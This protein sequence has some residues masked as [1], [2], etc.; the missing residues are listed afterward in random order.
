MSGQAFAADVQKT[1]VYPHPFHRAGAQE[2]RRYCTNRQQRPQLLATRAS[3]A[4]GLRATLSKATIL[5]ASSLTIC[6]C[7]SQEILAGAHET[8]ETHYSSVENLEAVDS[9]ALRNAHSTIDMCAYSLT[10]HALIEAIS[11]AAQKGV[12]VRIYLDRG[13][14]AG[15]LNRENNHYSAD[16]AVAESEGILRHLAGTPNVTVRVKHSNTLMH[17][18]SYLIDSELLRTGSAN[19][20]PTGEKRQDNDLAFSRDSVSIHR[21]KDNFARLWSRSDNEPLLSGD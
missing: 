16:S 3:R 2:R 6:S 17:L 15:E 14:T 20:S 18:K 13:Q 21:F 19:F 9:T 8:L 1:A 10:D 7:R 4:A 12:I 5:L 11:Q